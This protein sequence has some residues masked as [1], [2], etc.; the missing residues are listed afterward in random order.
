MRVDLE[1]EKRD[2][3]VLVDHAMIRVSEAGAHGLLRGSD[4]LSPAREVDGADGVVVGGEA[5]RESDDHADLAGGPCLLHQ[6]VGDDLGPGASAARGQRRAEQGRKQDR[7][8]EAG[9]RACHFWGA[10]RVSSSTRT[11]AREALSTRSVS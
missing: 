3:V 11:T 5:G 4:V 2:G 9:S 8:D 6:V 7:C 1:R 10:A